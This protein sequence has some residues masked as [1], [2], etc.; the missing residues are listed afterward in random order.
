MQ[1]IALRYIEHMNLQIVSQGPAD[2]MNQKTLKLKILCVLM[3]SQEEISFK[4]FFQPLVRM[5]I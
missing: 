1:D 3:G 5:D 4:T 2:L